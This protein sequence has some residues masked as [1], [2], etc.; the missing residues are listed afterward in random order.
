VLTDDLAALLSLFPNDALRDMRGLMAETKSYSP[1][2]TSRAAEV[3]RLPP[4]ADLRPHAA[5][6][7]EEVIYW[8]S[9]DLWRLFGR[10]P[11]WREAVLQVAKLLSIKLSGDGSDTHAWQIEAAILR[12]AL[13]DWE[14]LSPGKRE[15]ALRKSGVNWGA[16]RGA[17][18]SFAGTGLRVAAPGLLDL[19]AG[20]SP[21]I[22]GADTTAAPFVAVFAP[23][24]AVLGGAW[25]AYD[26]LAPSYRV[27]RPLTLTIAAN[28]QLLRDAAAASAFE[29]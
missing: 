4:T 14:K 25:A 20:G 2:P 23:V 24:F 10:T 19:L 13:A 27:V 28:R 5:E 7:A 16:A 17:T 11:T 12:K 9:H 1:F 29:D 22:A 21:L 6:L 18:A 3:H 26:L 8:A 15:E